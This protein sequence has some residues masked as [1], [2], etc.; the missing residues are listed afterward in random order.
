MHHLG[1]L[2]FPNIKT[3]F[4]HFPPQLYDLE[5]TYRI[6]WSFSRC[7]LTEKMNG[8]MIPGLFSFFSVSLSAYHYITLSTSL[9]FCADKCVHISNTYKISKFISL[10]HTFLQ[11]VYIQLLVKHASW[12]FNKHFSLNPFLIEL[13]ITKCTCYSSNLVY[14]NTWANLST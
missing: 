1:H 10:A 5:Q 7:F 3:I 13:L 11:N 9:P 12:V 6:I 14:L 4:S 2:V 8:Y